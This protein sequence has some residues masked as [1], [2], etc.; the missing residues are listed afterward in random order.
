MSIWCAPQ[1]WPSLEP[2]EVHVW[3]LDVENN[4]AALEG[5]RETL[6][7]EE[8]LRSSRYS[9]A[10][11][12]SRNIIAHGA[13]RTILAQYVGK[14]PSELLFRYSPRGKPE[15]ETKDV[16]FNM[17]HSHDLILYAVSLTC[18]VGVDVEHVRPSVDAEVARAFS[19]EAARSLKDLSPGRRRKCFYQAWTRMEAY[20][21]ACG[22]GLESD[23]ANFQ[24]FL[25]LKSPIG[26][27]S[28][29]AT[30]TACPWLIQDIR[31]RLGYVAALAIPAERRL[32]CWKW[33][34]GTWS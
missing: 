26:Y 11:E 16:W 25:E 20:A 31:P 21:K 28:M 17:S 12:R 2:D 7:A 5:L 10:L 24:S 32:L 27:P 13:L 15:L 14:S 34:T 30:S 29:M 33:K 19:P 6:R 1:T 9:V 18:P 8:L 3:R 23:L 22:E 4:I